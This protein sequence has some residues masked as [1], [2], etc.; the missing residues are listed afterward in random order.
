MGPEATDV[1]SRILAA[2]LPV[3]CLDTC[4]ILDILR[5]PTRDTASSMDLAVALE[6]LARVEQQDSLVVLVCDQVLVEFG[7]HIDEVA[8]ECATQLRKLADKV[9]A[10]DGIASQF[11]ASESAATN[12][13]HDHPGR[14][15]SVAD[16]LMNA[17][18]RVRQSS[19]VSPRA[20]LR[21]MQ[22]RAPA[23]KGKN[24]LKDCTVIE[25]Y[26]EAICCLREQG[27]SQ[28]AVFLSSNVHDYCGSN[29]CLHGDLQ[30]DFAGPKLDF[31]ISYEV[32][33]GKLGLRPLRSATTA[34]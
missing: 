33:R 7:D 24:S 1:V 29:R 31:A 8:D 23:Q 25:T 30:A 15:R 2:G 17:A 5:D 32:A 19:D 9:R 6:L 16:R 13:F 34:L 14:A 10:V 12:H 21:A 20:Y 4:S 22:G 18:Q 3:L 28:R 26:L 11:G 27:F